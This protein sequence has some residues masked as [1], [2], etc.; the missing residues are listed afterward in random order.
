MGFQHRVMGV[1]LRGGIGTGQVDIFRPIHEVPGPNE[2]AQKDRPIEQ[3][4]KGA[5]HA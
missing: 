1:L 2:A 4:T 3:R 5:G